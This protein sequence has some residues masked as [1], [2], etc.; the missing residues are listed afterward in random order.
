MTNQEAKLILQAYRAGG[1][2]ASD[3]LFAEALEQA[4]RDPELQKWFAEECAL[5]AQIQAKL[6]RA[7]PI[8]FNLK[9]SLLAQRKI[10]RPRAFW[11]SALWRQ[12]A[13]LTAAAAAVVLFVA[14]GMIW[15]KPS[16][17]PQ[18]ASFEQTM[19]QNSMRETNHISLMAQKMTQVRDWLKTQNVSTDFQVPASLRDA[20]L[21]GCKVIDWH[22]QKVTMLCFMPNGVGHVDL[23]V[24][25]CTRFRDF[26]P[27]E[28]AQF[29]KA[30]GL[31]TAVW[32][33]GNKTYLLAGMVNEEQLRKIL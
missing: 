10:V 26:K 18:F 2:D 7:I 22:G 19:V 12:P 30:D 14:A 3:P 25:D 13:W 1:Q 6:Q 15:F 9:A 8:P 16:S 17:Q 33:Q 23:F 21:H 24:V 11:L 27:S 4:R 5:D 32:R 31:T 20:M 28:M 29:A